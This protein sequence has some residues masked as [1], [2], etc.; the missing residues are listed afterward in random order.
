MILEFVVK[1]VWNGLLSK[2]IRLFGQK[3]FESILTIYITVFV[4]RGRHF[5]ARESVWLYIFEAKPRKILV[6][7]TQGPQNDSRGH[8]NSVE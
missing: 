4:T 8:K 5:G 6:K 7:L 1:I 3:I 2:H